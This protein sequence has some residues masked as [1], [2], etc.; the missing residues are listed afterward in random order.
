MLKE[1][2]K[3]LNQKSLSAFE[4]S[5]RLRADCRTPNPCQQQTQIAGT[6]APGEDFA[7]DISGALREHLR[8][9]QAACP[10]EVPKRPL[11]ALP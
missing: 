8:A 10:A 4:N 2:T 5:E 7:T 1:N 11:A 3:M 9:L 6:A